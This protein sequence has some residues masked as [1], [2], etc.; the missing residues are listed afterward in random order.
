[1]KYAWRGKATKGGTMNRLQEITKRRSEIR[2]ML[3]NESIE[4]DLEGV[5][6]ELEDLETEERKILAELEDQEA[7]EKRKMEEKRR[8][9]SE[10]EAGAAKG[11]GID[12]RQEEKDRM[13]QKMAAVLMAFTITVAPAMPSIFSAVPTMVWSALKLMQATASKLE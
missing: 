1:M 4:V 5:K 9:A 7:M 11:K 6:A 12:E 13:M 2:A 3:E 10:L 8:I